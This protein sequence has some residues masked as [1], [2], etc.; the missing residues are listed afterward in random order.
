MTGEVRRIIYLNEQGKLQRSQ[1]GEIVNIGGTSNSTF[2]VDGK[3]LMFDDGTSTSGSSGGIGNINLSLQTAYNN[4]K[5]NIGNTLNVNLKAGQDLVFVGENGLHYF[6]IDGANGNIELNGQVNG[7]P[8]SDITNHISVSSAI[9][10]N[11]SEISVTPITQIPT[12]TNVQE[13]LEQINTV[14]QNN[15]IAD[16]SGFEHIQ[17]NPLSTWTVVHGKN[18]KRLQWTIWDD[19]DEWVL[20]DSV[21]IN[22]QNTI[23]INFGMPQSGR[24]ILMSF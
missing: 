7:I 20:P 3:G 14:I 5:T 1:N 15:E 12:A 21:I 13:A 19:N 2:T 8:F 6:K 24:L 4:Q 17:V 22:D 9:K 16:V 11:A 10:H 18:T 23:T